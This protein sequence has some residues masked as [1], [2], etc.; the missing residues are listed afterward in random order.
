MSEQGHKAVSSRFEE[1]D[2]ER[3][4][5]IAKRDGLSM[6]AFVRM[7]ALREATAREHATA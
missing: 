7:A 6:A 2:H 3:I 4:R 5:K 1:Q